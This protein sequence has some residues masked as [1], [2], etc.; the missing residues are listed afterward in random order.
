MS[1][2][3]ILPI[4]GTTTVYFFSC[5]SC[6]RLEKWSIKQFVS[7]I[8]KIGWI[9]SSMQR[10]RSFSISFWKRKVYTIVILFLWWY[11][12][13]YHIITR[14]LCIT[15]H[16][17]TCTF[18]KMEFKRNMVRYYYLEKKDKSNWDTGRLYSYQNCLV[19]VALVFLSLKLYWNC[20]HFNHSFHYLFITIITKVTL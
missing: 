18:K 8:K 6:L 11:Y 19:K 14:L 4:S 17:Y 7:G 15:L 12:E 13:I 2:T 5:M 20:V 1:N 10:W 16:R 9:S 3:T